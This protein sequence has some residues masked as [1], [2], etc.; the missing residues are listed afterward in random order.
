MRSCNFKP[1]ESSVIVHFYGGKQEGDHGNGQD[2]SGRTTENVEAA[3]AVVVVAVAVAAVVAVV[4]AAAAA[5]AV[6]VVAV[7]VVVVVVVAAVAV[8][9]VKQRAQ[10]QQVIEKGVQQKM[11]P[12][13]GECMNGH[14]RGCGR[15]CRRQ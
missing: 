6:A 15:L 3:A 8:A 9:V 5:V 7:V 2:Q 4:V 14:Q 11:T 12:E 10:A 13:S 1:Q